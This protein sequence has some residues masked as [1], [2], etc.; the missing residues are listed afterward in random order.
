MQARG[1]LTYTTRSVPSAAASSFLP[2]QVHAVAF[3]P[4]SL[5]RVTA[6]DAEI[7]RAASALGTCRVYL[8][9]FDESVGEADISQLDEFIQR[10]SDHSAN[11]IARQIIG[12]FHEA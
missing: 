2:S 6:E 4:A 12:F 10:S 7:I 9:A 11:T 5:A 1:S 3:T 8:V